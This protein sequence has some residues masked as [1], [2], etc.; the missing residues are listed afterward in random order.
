M[1]IMEICKYYHSYHNT[2]FCKL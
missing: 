2:Y 1:N